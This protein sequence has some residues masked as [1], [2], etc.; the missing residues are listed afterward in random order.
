MSEKPP[1]PD[2][3]EEPEA[4]LGDLEGLFTAALLKLEE[5]DPEGA[6]EDLEAILKVDPRLAEP[7]LEL[8][9]LLL[10]ADEFD[11]AEDQARE[12][13]RILETGGQWAEGLDENVLLGHAWSLLG[14]CLR[15]KAGTDEVL[16]GERDRWEAL[17]Q[18]SKTAFEKA[19]AVD[20]SNSEA[21]NWAFGLKR[22]PPPVSESS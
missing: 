19:A 17:V 6:R 20:P 4:H 22:A 3:L 13:L 14:E 16:F 18:E 12:G 8:A 9:R 11:Q 10:Q 5:G 2:L 21:K 7:R 1:A 15:C